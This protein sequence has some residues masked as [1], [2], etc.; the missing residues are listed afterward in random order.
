MWLERYL[1]EDWH[2][3]RN[4]ILLLKGFNANVLRSKALNF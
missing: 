3:N 2:S 4:F 1:T